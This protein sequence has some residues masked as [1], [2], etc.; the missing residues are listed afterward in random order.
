V[1]KAHREEAA[2]LPFRQ[3]QK[4]EEKIAQELAESIAGGRR[5]KDAFRPQ[6]SS[7]YQDQ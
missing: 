7:Q 3:R 4:R 6:L 2:K 5:A 1:R